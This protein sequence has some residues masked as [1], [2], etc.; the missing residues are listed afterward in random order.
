MAYDNTNKGAIWIRTAKSGLVYK[1]GTLNVEGK[2]YRITMFDNKKDG[3]EARPDFNVI[4]EPMDEQA[5]GNNG[6]QNQNSGSQQS[7]DLSI[8]DLPF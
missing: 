5:S 3:N 2:E 4:V 8:E 6:G 7:D 1:S